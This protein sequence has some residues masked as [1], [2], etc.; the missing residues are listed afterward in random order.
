MFLP[1]D[2]QW[3]FMEKPLIDTTEVT[4]SSGQLAFAGEYTVGGT[5]W[6]ANAENME[7][8]ALSAADT[9]QVH[10]LDLMFPEAEEK[11]TLGRI[12]GK[13]PVYLGN[14]LPK[15]SAGTTPEARQKFVAAAK[16]AEDLHSAWWQSAD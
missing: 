10:Y 6:R 11:S 13:N 1:A 9:A 2:T 7:E 4:V 5:P 15:R 12:Y 16:R 14:Y 3:I 8:D